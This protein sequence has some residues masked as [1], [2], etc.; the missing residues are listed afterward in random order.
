M[1]RN[2]DSNKAYAEVSCS[3]N[4]FLKGMSKS[5]FFRTVNYL[6]NLGLITLIKKK[7]GRYYTVESQTLLSDESI[8]SVE[9]R[10]RL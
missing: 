3:D 4:I 2:Q 8:V 1:I 10:K 9:L 7:V 5:T 6:Q